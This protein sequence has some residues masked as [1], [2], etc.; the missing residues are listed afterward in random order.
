MKRDDGRWYTVVSY[1]VV[2]DKRRR[3]MA[4]VLKGFG[5][6]VQKSV[7]DCRLEERRLLDLQGILKNEM[8]EG[9][10]SVRYYRLCARCVGLVEVV[11]RGTV[12]EDEELIII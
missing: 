12:M 6:R 10:D 3:R 5:D 1:D 4:K 9:E 8:N 7:F 2:D 11:G